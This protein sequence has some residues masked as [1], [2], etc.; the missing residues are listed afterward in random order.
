MKAIVLTLFLRKTRFIFNALEN[1]EL[2]EFI[3]LKIK[4][5]LLR[6]EQNRARTYNLFSNYKVKIDILKKIINN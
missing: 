6:K 2:L 5:T 3:E 4:L 1:I